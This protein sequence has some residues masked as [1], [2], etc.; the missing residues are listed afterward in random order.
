MAL[1]VVVVAAVTAAVVLVI[2]V[3]IVAAIVITTTVTLKGHGDDALHP[4]QQVK[5]RRLRASFTMAHGMPLVNVWVNG[6]GPFRCVVDSGSHTLNIAS[7][8]CAS[9]DPHM[10]LLSGRHIAGH[11]T[12]VV[13][14]NTQR[15][16]TTML[17]SATVQVGDEVVHGVPTVVATARAST[18]PVTFNVLGILDDT[19]GGQALQRL[20]PAEG[21][22]LALVYKHAGGGFLCNASQIDTRVFHTRVAWRRP[23]RRLRYYTLPV[24]QVQCGNVLAN[25][26]ADSSRRAIRN[27]VVDTGSSSTSIPQQFFN[28]IRENL[29][30]NEPILLFIKG[31]QRPLQI[32]YTKYRVAGSATG[33]LLVNDDTTAVQ[34]R[35]DTIILGSNA[36]IGVVIGFSA[37][38]CLLGD[39]IAVA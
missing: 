14:Y 27:V 25:M 26:H 30:R 7:E 5:R 15:D 11:P 36:L 9:C 23:Q 22:A 31:A 39:A 37:T 1:T 24:A 3:A 38:H 12:T 28:A 29:Q 17:P 13:Q 8:L 16:H 32:D 10:G 19:R 21:D 18:S 34:P 20:M 33:G 6:Q 35:T 2:V 4:P